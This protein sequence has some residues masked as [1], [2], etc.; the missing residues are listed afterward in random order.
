M[1]SLT[2]SSP[3]LGL[4]RV[5]LDPESSRDSQ[6]VIPAVRRAF[7]RDA[8]VVGSCLVYHPRPQGKSGEA[9]VTVSGS[10]RRGKN[11]VRKLPTSRHILMAIASMGAIPLQFFIPLADFDPG[12]YTLEVRAQ[13]ENAGR[14]IVQDVDFLVR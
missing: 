5:D 7:S 2:L 10:I 14:G 1:S 4:R 11:T 8:E 12:V 6:I 9:R 13:D 3:E